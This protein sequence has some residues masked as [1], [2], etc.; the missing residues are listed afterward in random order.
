[1]SLP[2]ATGFA[3]AQERAEHLVQQRRMG[4]VNPL[5]GSPISLPGQQGQ[6]AYGGMSYPNQPPYPQ[7]QQQSQQMRPQW[8]PQPPRDIKQFP[9]QHQFPDVKQQTPHIKQELNQT[10]GAGDD[11][12][13]QAQ[14]AAVMGHQRELK[15][16]DQK[17][18]QADGMLKRHVSA[19][20]RR[21]EGGGVLVPIDQRYSVAE[22][23]GLPSQSHLGPV[24]APDNVKYESG[25]DTVA[26]FDGGDEDLEDEKDKDAINSDLDDPEEEVDDGTVGEEYEGDTIICLYDKVQRVKNKWKCTLKDGVVN[27]DGKE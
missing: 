3:N 20:M 27:A 23:Q 12:D 9:P 7:H 10:D 18:R 26:R 16:D 21:L 6:S 1:M 24:L 14:W 15:T 19:Q 2:P 25:V 8:A 17:V 5:Q 11:R 4:G 13:P 22:R